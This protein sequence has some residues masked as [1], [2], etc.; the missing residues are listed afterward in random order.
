MYRRFKNKVSEIK[1]IEYMYYFV[2][3]GLNFSIYLAIL[4]ADIYYYMNVLQSYFESLNAS[5]HKGKILKYNNRWKIFKIYFKEPKKVYKNKIINYSS[6]L[7][8]L[9]NIDIKHPNTK[10]YDQTKYKYFNPYSMLYYK[11]INLTY[12]FDVFFKKNKN[13]Y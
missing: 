10:F 4:N 9:S 6:Y 3:D 7:Y 8:N 11:S 1:E 13:I 5:F 2:V 12:N